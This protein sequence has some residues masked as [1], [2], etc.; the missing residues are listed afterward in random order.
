[1]GILLVLQISGTIPTGNYA[2][3][4][5]SS[6]PLPTDFAICYIGGKKAV[7]KR[8]FASMILSILLLSVGFLSR[9]IRLH[10]VLSVDY[11]GKT[12]YLLSGELRFQLRRLHRKCVV[13]RSFR[14]AAFTILY[15]ILL[16]IFI[17][18]RVVADVWTSMFFEVGN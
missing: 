16:G 8:T 10:K 12:R 3:D 13:G 11:I 2:W 4:F 17:L 14:S 6:E 18:M 15:R 9:V 7:V 5:G 1:M